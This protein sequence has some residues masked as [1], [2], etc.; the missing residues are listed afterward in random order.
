MAA[1]LGCAVL[2]L[3]PNRYVFSDHSWRCFNCGAAVRDQ[4]AVGRDLGDGDWWPESCCGDLGR[5]DPGD[6][7]DRAGPMDQL[8]KTAADLVH[9]PECSICQH[10]VFDL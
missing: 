3:W 8:R 9:D 4:G 2:Y 7:W 5:S 10:V 1:S 6:D